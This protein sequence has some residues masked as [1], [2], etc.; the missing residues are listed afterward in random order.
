MISSFANLASTELI[1]LIAT[2]AI[3]VLVHLSV[4]K[5]SF[6]DNVC[7]LIK[8][9]F[10][11]RNNQPILYSYRHVSLMIASYFLIICSLLVLNIF[12]LILAIYAYCGIPISIELV[13]YS[14]LSIQ[15]MAILSASLI[16]IAILLYYIRN[17]NNF[18]SLLKNNYC[19]LESLLSILLCAIYIGA[20]KHSRPIGTTI[21]SVS[22]FCIV[23]TFCFVLLCVF[24]H[25]LQSKKKESLRKLLFGNTKIRELVTI[26]KQEN[27]ELLYNILLCDGLTLLI[28]FYVDSLASITIVKAISYILLQVLFVG[29][30]KGYKTAINV[31]IKTKEDK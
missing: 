15:I 17:N 25:K 5:M 23:A 30:T 16:A 3:S 21:C 12:Y 31:T 14:E 18:M 29:I 4:L 26:S 11:I 2:F 8:K 9:L 1:Y 10:Q 13:S 20:T 6:K 24:L 7:F 28:I 19:L 22:S 27:I